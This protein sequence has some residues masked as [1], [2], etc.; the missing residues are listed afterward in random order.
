MNWNRK[1][2]EDLNNEA[3]NDAIKFLNSASNAIAIIDATNH[4]KARRI[5]L[6]ENVS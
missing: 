6:V 4:Y 1:I 5:E 2:R 3:Q